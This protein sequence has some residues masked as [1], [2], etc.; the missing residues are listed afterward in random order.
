MIEKLNDE[1]IIHIDFS[2]NYICKYREETQS[3]Y[4][5]ASKK[6]LSIHTGVAYNKDKTI[7]LA[8]VSDNLNHSPPAIWA[9]LHPIITQFK[10]EYPDIS[11]LHVISNGPTTQYRCKNNFYLFA[12][13]IFEYGFGAGTWTFLEAGHDKGAQDG[14]R[15]AIKRS[16]DTI[17]NGKGETKILLQILSKVIYTWLRI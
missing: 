2:E 6:Q 16:A 14:V 10:E 4:F 17:V 5:G 11:K 1:L 7:T 13:K 3:V 9:Q 15:A 12:T 8:R